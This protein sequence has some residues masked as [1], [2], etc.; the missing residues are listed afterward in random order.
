MKFFTVLGTMP[1]SYPPVLA[2]HRFEF[3]GDTAEHF[4]DDELRATIA[5]ADFPAY[6]DSAV[7]LPSGVDPVFPVDSAPLLPAI[8]LDFTAPV[9]PVVT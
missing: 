9:V 8:D 7:S 3:R 1:G 5:R 4:I 6:L 2:W